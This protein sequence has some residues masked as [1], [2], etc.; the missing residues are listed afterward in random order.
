MS[1]GQPV[2]PS[3]SV[4][5]VYVHCALSMQ[6]SLGS[7]NNIGSVIGSASK[8]RVPM[9]EQITSLL[10]IDLD[11][12]VSIGYRLPV[13]ALASLALTCRTL[14]HHITQNQSLWSVKYRQDFQNRYHD[15]VNVHDWPA[16]Y[17]AATAAAYQVG[18]NSLPK[19]ATYTHATLNLVP[20]MLP[21]CSPLLAYAYQQRC[22]AIVSSS[23]C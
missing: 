4:I 13:S 16:A 20:C 8:A 23:Q 2:C 10:C 3:V 1:G 15:I 9:T 21:S 7:C 22:T 11:A 12:W 17:R 19:Q 6:N 18:D 5:V 14:N